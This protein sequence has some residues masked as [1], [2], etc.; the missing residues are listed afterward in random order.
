MEQI[1][2]FHVSPK[3]NRK[4]IQK[5]GLKPTIIRHSEHAKYFDKLNLT[6]TDNK[7]LYTWESVIDNSKFIKDH[8]SC[9]TW[10]MPR[11]K[12]YKNSDHYQD[13]SKLLNKNLY[14]ETEMLFDVWMS[15]TNTT[16]H[17]LFQHSQ[18][19]VDDKRGSMYRF[20]NKYSHTNKPLRVFNY[21]LK[22]KLVGKGV[23]RF[24]K[25]KIT[26]KILK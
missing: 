5:Y 25:N 18:T 4:S 7:I 26:I 14:F 13:F 3:Y 22:P 1:E 8:I 24:E 2:V 15:K 6:T 17:N 23:Y 20:D 12:I 19:P 9:I 16:R 10:I 11:D 21:P